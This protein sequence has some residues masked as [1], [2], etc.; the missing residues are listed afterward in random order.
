MSHDRV[1]IVAG[2]WS[3]D[4]RRWAMTL[5]GCLLLVAALAVIAGHGPP[6]PWIA[7]LLPGGWFR[8]VVGGAGAV[9]ALWV[10][11]R[12]GAGGEGLRK[13]R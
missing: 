6:A 13:L 3:R 2:L 10:L 5:V 9:T 8:A 12:A 7:A 11:R 1:P 4:P